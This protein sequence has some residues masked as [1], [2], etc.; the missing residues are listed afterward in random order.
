MPNVVSVLALGVSSC[1]V[2]VTTFFLCHVQNVCDLRPVSIALLVSCHSLQ[3][4]H[5]DVDIF[6]SSILPTVEARD[7]WTETLLWAGL[8][9]FGV[10]DWVHRRTGGTI[11]SDCGNVTVIVVAV[12]GLISLG[13]LFLREMALD[14][15]EGAGDRTAHTPRTTNCSAAHP[16]SSASSAD[17]AWEGP[18]IIDR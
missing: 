10:E 9:Y 17:L 18:S 5:S 11:V 6:I 7:D 4:L 3:S 14:T 16:A 1:R 15:G 13:V 8:E 12:K 2:P